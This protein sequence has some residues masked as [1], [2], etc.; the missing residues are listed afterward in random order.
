MAEIRVAEVLSAL[1]L[2]T[3]LA[4]G[5]PFE[6]GLRTCLVASVFADEVLGVDATTLRSVFETA[7]LRSVGCTSFA[8]ELAAIFGDDVAFQAVLKTFEPGDEEK[9]ATQLSSHNDRNAAGGPGPAIAPMEVFHA[10]GVEAMRSG[11]EASRSLGAGLG[12]RPESIEALDH[13]YE[14]WDGHGIPGVLG[15]KQLALAVRV[16]HLAEQAVL[17]HAVG[18]LPA[19]VSEVRRRSGGHLDPQLA[20]AFV[21]DPV[22][23]MAPL[24]QPDA[25]RAV[26]DVEPRPHVTFPF[27]SLP[28]LCAVLAR[29]VDLKSTWFLGHSERVATLAEAAGRLAGFDTAAATE[30]RCAGLLHDLGRVGVSSSTW[31]RPGPLGLAEMERVRMYPY[32][33]HRILDRV[34]AL[35]AIAPIASAHHERVDGCGY[36][37]GVSSLQLT[38]S[39]RILAAADRFVAL[40]EARPY[41]AAHTVDAA[42]GT[43]MQDVQTGG[44]DRQACAVVIEAAGRP[45][46]RS[47]LPAGLTEREVE[48]LCQAARGLSNR[49]IGE[50]LQI[51]GRTVGHHLS[52]IYDKIG[53]RTRAGVAVFAMEHGLLP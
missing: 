38:F 35:A 45:R 3:D 33:T 16:V 8:P 19:A 31:D 32:W 36:H 50:Q 28:Q 48:V 26:L 11:C 24:D 30:L 2:T 29:L 22:A 20:E 47:K 14:R 10:V 1:S 17:A 41:R 13:V 4:A 27:G 34:P 40:T 18:G 23:S 46:P 49:E 37:R 15:G 39:A 7:L 6:K 52:H 5:V 9:F 42:V 44:L 51:S 12:L 25:I 43:L 21:A 53:L